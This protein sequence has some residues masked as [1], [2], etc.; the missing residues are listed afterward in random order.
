[1]TDYLGEKY[2]EKN[3]PRTIYF[4]SHFWRHPQVKKFS[5]EAKLLFIT[6]LAHCDENDSYKFCSERIGLEIPSLNALS[7]EKIEASLNELLDLGFINSD[8]L[9]N[10]ERYLTISDFGKTFF[11][12]SVR[13]AIIS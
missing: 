9:D 13:T 3:I 2:S 6:L 1:M 8:Q 10:E 11:K 7:K 12:V 5:S 4:D